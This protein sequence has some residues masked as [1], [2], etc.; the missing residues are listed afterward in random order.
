MV[1]PSFDLAQEILTVLGEPIGFTG[2]A[3]VEA[4]AAARM[5]LDPWLGVSVTPG[6]VPGVCDGRGSVW[7]MT[8]GASFLARRQTC[9]SG[10]GARDSSGR[11]WRPGGVTPLVAGVAWP[12]SAP[13]GR[14]ES[15]PR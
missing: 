6:A 14:S 7:S 4:L 11:L 3:D 10:P 12:G 5:A 13:G 1:S 9:C 15:R 2:V 8:A